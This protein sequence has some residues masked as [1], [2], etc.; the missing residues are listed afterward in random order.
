MNRWYHELAQTLLFLQRSP[1]FALQPWMLCIKFV[2]NLHND[3]GKEFMF[4]FI[5]A[6]SSLS[7]FKIGRGP[8]LE[9]TWNSWNIIKGCFVQSL[10]EIGPMVL[11]KKIFNI[12]QC[13]FAISLLSPLVKRRGP[14]LLTVRSLTIHTALTALL[15][16]HYPSEL[17]RWEICIWIL[18]HRYE[19]KKHPWVV[20][21][22]LG[23][24]YM[25]VAF[26]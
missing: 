13:V 11:E 12:R 6:N 23:Y 5:F 3:S 18:S 2:W 19:H 8:S 15:V 1:S 4:Q 20:E 7:S 26:N 25:C 24:W 10:V 16:P 21:N 9:Q 14:S 17:W 22:F